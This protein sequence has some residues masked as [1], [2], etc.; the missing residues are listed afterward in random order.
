MDGVDS[1]IDKVQKQA[2]RKVDV[3]QTLLQK[4]IITKDQ[5][6][7]AERE[8]KDHNLSDS[9]ENL[10]VKLGFITDDVLLDTLNSQAEFG[11][12]KF[13]LKTTIIDQRLVQKI[14][15]SFAIQNKVIPVS[16][17]K[18]IIKVAVADIYDIITI[19]QIKRF[20]PNNF[21]II[22]VLAL[23]NDIVTA[24][25]KYYG[26]NL[27]IDSILKE[28]EGEGSAD[29]NDKD[30]T[31]GGGD[32]Y[33]SPIV[34][35]VDA[36]LIDA[37]RQGASDLHFEPEEYFL[38]LRYRI[39][40]KMEQ[41]RVFHNKYW[42]AILVRIKIISGMNIAETRKQQ[43]GR[44][45]T[46]ILGRNIDFRVSIQPT[47]GGENIVMRIL[48]QKKSVL[49]LEKAGF[50]KRN[51]DI[52]NR[53][54]KKP[55]GVIILTGPTGSGKT[56][57]LYTLLNMINKPDI[58]IMTLENPVE[59]RL[60]MIRQSNINPEIGV[61]FAEGIRT[62]LRQ[63]PDVILV[64]EIRDEATA[65]AAIQAAMTGHQVY[66]SLH[67]NDAFSAIPRLLQ[68]GVQPFLLSGALIAVVAQRLARTICPHCKEQIP[69]T[70]DQRVILE[71]ILGKE[72]VANVSHLY[73]GKGCDKCKGKGFVG[74]TT[75]NEIL[76]VD[77][78]IDDMIVREARKKEILEYLEKRGYV[79]MQ[80]DGARKVI[81]GITTID[82]LSRVVDLTQYFR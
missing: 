3:L 67:T 25:D 26:Y 57:T 36:L 20:F 40:G 13:D 12:D 32:T 48:D 44:I 37:V 53:C 78:E 7:V 63:D 76:D 19:D 16:F 17:N 2:S 73:R 4:G 80:M 61:T 35:L 54:I 14:P 31:D 15:K 74:R 29:K 47:V 72:E 69:I 10:L 38:R 22:P 27:D 23:E 49:T 51:L 11:S 68:I 56:T 70:D 60:P 50:S 81:A 24:I 18:D 52:I 41:V 21:K 9:I 75:V 6:G 55:E 64:G 45:Q 5:V 66:S 46:T 1:V 58:N 28:I 65:L 30:N 77:R 59:Y 33:K 71:K 43:D 82:E 34:R 79:T 8:K 62:L 42:N 39:D